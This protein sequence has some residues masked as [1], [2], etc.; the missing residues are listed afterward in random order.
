M[1]DNLQ[2]R[3]LSY[4]LH[5]LY[6]YVFITTQNRSLSVEVVLYCVN[7]WYPPGNIGLPLASSV[8]ALEPQDD[9]IYQTP[10]INCWCSS[11]VGSY[12]RDTSPII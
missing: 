7:E 6:E 1:Q 10:F 5:Y 12:W 3:K 8:L 9:V 11:N 2:M 4:Y